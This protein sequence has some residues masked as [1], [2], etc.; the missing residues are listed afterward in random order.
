MASLSST[1]KVGA[2]LC[3][4][5]SQRP[6]PSPVHSCSEQFGMGPPQAKL[7]GLHVSGGNRRSSGGYV[8]FSEESL[9]RAAYRGWVS[10]R[11][12]EEWESLVVPEMSARQT[13]HPEPPTQKAA[14][15]L[16]DAGSQ[17]FLCQCPVLIQS[18]WTQ[19]VTFWKSLYCSF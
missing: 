10:W 16:E 13:E 2:L 11:D 3:S 19:K 15:A 1:C 9:A 8:G 18:T 7:A 4:P 12:R 5:A 6:P 14:C 17:L